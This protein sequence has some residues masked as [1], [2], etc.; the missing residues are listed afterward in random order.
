MPPDDA[1]ATTQG[2]IAPFKP[3]IAV[4]AVA[5][6]QSEIVKGRIDKFF[7]GMPVFMNAL[8]AVGDLHPFIGGMLNL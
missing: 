4:A 2:N 1:V 6:E 7:E 5:I 8:D 3:L